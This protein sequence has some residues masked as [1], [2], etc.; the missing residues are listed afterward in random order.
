[1]KTVSTAA[2]SKQAMMTSSNGNIFRVTG[3]LCGN[4]PVPVNSPHKGQWRG[5]LMFSLICVWINGWVNN[6]EA[7]DLRRNRCHYDVIVMPYLKK[8]RKCVYIS[9]YPCYHGK[10]NILN[11]HTS[12]HITSRC[13]THD[14]MLSVYFQIRHPFTKSH[15]FLV[16]LVGWYVI[17]R[18]M[19]IDVTKLLALSRNSP[20]TGEFTEASDAEL[21]CYIWPAP[22]LTA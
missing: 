21:G 10:G 5:A 9:M 4:S 1:M 13:T 18:Y 2:E 6:H 11:N 22:E 7:G 16:F 3:P 20:V 14:C 12:I 19:H 8:R 17:Y 15:N